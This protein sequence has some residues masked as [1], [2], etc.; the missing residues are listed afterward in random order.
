MCNATLK[1]VFSSGIEALD[2]MLQGI[3][4]GDNVVWQ[5][6]NLKDVMPFVH[7][8]CRWVHRDRKKLVYFRF[9][10]HE[11]LVP[12]EFEAEVHTLNAKAGFEQF[13]TEILNVVEKSGKHGVCY[14]FDCLSGLAKDWYSDR[15]LGN[16]FKMACPYLFTSQTVAY[17]A[18]IR[19]RH[20]P[21]SI[22]AI[23]STA[24]VVLDLYRSNGKDYILPLKVKGRHTSTM[25][26][27]HALEGGNFEPVTQSTI[28]SEILSTT[29][30]P[31][32]DGNLARRD[33]WM[34]I[35]EEAQAACSTQEK[36]SST[37]NNKSLQKQLIK[38]LVTRSKAVSQLC[39]EHFELSDL[40]S[41]G[42]RMIGT[43]LIGGKSTG[44][45]LARAILKN[46][47]PKWDQLME[48]HDSFFIGADVFYSFVIN[49]KCWW[50]RHQMKTSDDPYVEA[51]KIR[52]K[53][54]NGKFPR[55]IIDQFAEIL[56]YFG[57]S[58]IIVRSS[59]LLED[60]YGNAFS[61]KYESVFCVNQGTPKERLE[62]FKDAVRTVYA[63]S[64]SQD[65][66]TYR[67]HRGL[68]DRNEEMAL[69]VQRV[70]GAFYENLYLPQLAGVG[71][72][73]NP[74]VWDPEINPSDGVLRLVFG[75]GTRA[76]DQHDDEYT[77]I[78]ALNA[79]LKRPE[80][81]AD[82]VYRYSQHVVDV[83]DLKNNIHTSTD[84]ET[85]AK[86][87]PGLPLE[88]FAVRDREMEKRARQHG[89]QNIFS[90]MLTFKNVFTETNLV[91]DMRE[92]L[93]TLATAYDY[94]V[95]I[96]FAI[97]FSSDDSYRINLLQCRPFQVNVKTSGAKLPEN[98]K[99][100]DI[101]LKTSGPIIGQAVAQKIDR[102]I[103]I[104]PSKYSTLT[105]SERFSVASLIGDLTNELPDDKN[106]M[107]VGPGRWGSKMPELGVPI[108]FN[109]IRNA[110]VL[111]ELVTMHEK[112]TPDIS[113][114]TH[115]FNDLVEMG[116][117]YIGIYPGDEGYVL[118]EK[119][120]LQGSNVLSKI[121][122]KND[123]IAQA[124]H[125]SDID[126]ALSSL[127]FHANTLNQKGIV[128]QVKN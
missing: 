30:Q 83:L 78:V 29:P 42:K 80:A 89:V 70:S 110:S 62:Q 79:P 24:Q 55:D 76:V 35:L 96:E 53:L 111:C 48:I 3:I 120:I 72:S 75:L 108:S 84:F 21:H 14:V 54:L 99:E 123:A 33:T 106:V 60:A 87:T 98:I 56:N 92:M 49:N 128:Y 67:L 25:Y 32:T 126:N 73:F 65:V 38:M 12:D 118:N 66:L 45:L 17:F 27:L 113:L 116:I 11:A 86:S 77:R 40:V 90:W 71:Y 20:T 7:A 37:K 8:F 127:F 91:N 51:E 36:R 121:Y 125:V 124:I 19:N 97:N 44:M 119:L 82:D 23:H 13:I 109:D 41:I 68:W 31:W 59:S 88:L 1:P 94:P 10:S 50:E 69:L 81:S 26:M 57:Q 43:G 64:M 100:K 34:K 115:F 95:D 93:K 28:V 107:L 63:S 104:I 74:F 9:A 102:I 114:G 122:N 58:P 4:A 85:V 2:E 16:F 103:Y 22:N 6:D 105:T 46:A 47:H 101:F 39:E 18:L 52:E 117:V 15:V 112:L 5:V 61:G